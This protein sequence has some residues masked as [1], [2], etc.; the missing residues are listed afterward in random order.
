MMHFVTDCQ[1][2]PQLGVV[3]MS[4]RA[5]RDREEAAPLLQPQI[6]EIPGV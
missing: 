3:F 6:S 2:S 1:G 5:G 4:S